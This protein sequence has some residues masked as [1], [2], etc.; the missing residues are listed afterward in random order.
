MG[1]KYESGE[2]SICTMAKAVN[3][4]IP[5]KD[6]CKITNAMC[7]FYEDEGM[8]VCKSKLKCILYFIKQFKKGR[9]VKLSLIFKFLSSKV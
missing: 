5:Y 1:T 2:L 9:K 4:D 6:I 7:P 8:C 3:K